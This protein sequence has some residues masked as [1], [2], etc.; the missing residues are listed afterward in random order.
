MNNGG[1][2]AHTIYF[3]KEKPAQ[4]VKTQESSRNHKSTPVLVIIE[5]S[6]T[7]W[8]G[9]EAEVED[10]YQYKEKNRAKKHPKHPKG[11]YM[12]KNSKK[13]QETMITHLFQERQ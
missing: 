2:G 13:H 11:S 7:L 3:R 12:T 4:K 10:S 1:I 5:S 9:R 8:D 6:G